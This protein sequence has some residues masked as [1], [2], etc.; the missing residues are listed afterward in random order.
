MVPF[1][2]KDSVTTIQPET[3]QILFHAAG[4]NKAQIIQRTN[5]NRTLLLDVI[6]STMWYVPT[7]SRQQNAA[8]A[9]KKIAPAASTSNVDQHQKSVGNI[10][11][12]GE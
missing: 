7:A 1:A 9:A 4:A 5:K 3:R 8:K 6:T 12:A 11:H 10:R 2:A